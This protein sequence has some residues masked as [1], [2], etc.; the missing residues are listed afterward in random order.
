MAKSLKKTLVW[1]GVAYLL[2]LVVTFPAGLALGLA[3]S[4]QAG[5]GVADVEG[6][7]WGGRA[8]T[9]ATSGISMGPVV[10]DW[11]PTALLFGR[12][13]YDVYFEMA[14]GGGEARL[15]RSLLGNTYM[16]EVAGSLDGRH[17]NSLVA[18]PGAELAG[19]ILIDLDE[20]GFDDG[21]I[22]GLEGTVLWENAH[23]VSP[24]AVNLGSLEVELTG[25]D[26]QINGVVSDKGGPL[27]VSGGIALVNGKNYSF[28][29]KVKP[30]ENADPAL[31]DALSMLG[32]PDRSGAYSVAYSGT[33]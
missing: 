16:K 11:R 9:V 13:E 1:G 15:G 5:V 25:E 4:P 14:G 30:R 8:A 29:A 7:V 23:V 17:I 3:L 20:V 6:T 22:A 32:Q 26:A 19:S 31:T 33:L 21:V 28:N 2:F 24:M 27:A 10:W 18:I 12:F